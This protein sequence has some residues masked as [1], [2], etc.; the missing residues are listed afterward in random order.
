LTLAALIDLFSRRVGG[1][2]M[3]KSIDTALVFFV[4]NMADHRPSAPRRHVIL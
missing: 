1:W 2:A 3:S 4:L